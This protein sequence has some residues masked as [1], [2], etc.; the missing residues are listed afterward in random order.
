MKMR[1]KDR[2]GRLEDIV[3]NLDD[4]SSAIGY[5]ACDSSTACSFALFRRRCGSTSAAFPSATSLAACR[6]PSDLIAAIELC[7]S[8]LESPNL[9]LSV[10]L[11]QK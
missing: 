10:E 9:A 7:S 6:P 11:A 2:C 4:A 8:L 3:A 5:A 1:F